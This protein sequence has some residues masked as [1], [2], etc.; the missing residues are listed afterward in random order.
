MLRN[1][2]LVSEKEGV[3][4]TDDECTIITMITSLAGMETTPAN[5]IDKT[6]CVSGKNKPVV[7]L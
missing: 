3:E 7:K 1:Q 2:V 5:L 6:G 4:Q